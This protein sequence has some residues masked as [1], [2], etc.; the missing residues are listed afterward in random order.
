[1]TRISETTDVFIGAME[2]DIDMMKAAKSVKDLAIVLAESYRSTVMAFVKEKA[3]QFSDLC[4]EVVQLREQVDGQRVWSHKQEEKVKE[5]E[6]LRE[7]TIVK[8]A[9][10]E[11]AAKMEVATTQVKVLDLDFR[12]QVEE[13]SE[14][15]RE[16]RDILRQKVKDM[17]KP[18]YDELVRKAVVQVLARQ[19]QKR[20]R[21]SDGEEIWTAPVVLSIK[22]RQ[23]RWDMEDLLRRNNVYP[24]FHWPKEFLEPMKKIRE[25]LKTKVDEDSTYVRLRPVN[26]DGKWRIRADVK[27]K[28]GG[29]RFVHKATWDMPPIDEAAR[30]LVPNWHKPTWADVV[31]RRSVAASVSMASVSRANAPDVFDMEEEE[32]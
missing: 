28:E 18:R 16:A 22:E 5:I 31:R 30:K 20:K 13:R 23:D 8:D 3:D 6:Q 14:L 15:T 17:D 27:P 2:N 12:K 11:M 19:T 4:N 25:V 9:R 7:S 10:K 21:R 32:T 24:T 1:L 26:N 29:G